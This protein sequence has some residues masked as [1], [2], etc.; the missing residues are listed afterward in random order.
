MRHH[1]TRSRA[2]AIA[3]GVTAGVLALGTAAAGTAA[4]STAPSAAGS[5]SAAARAAART[6]AQHQQHAPEDAVGAVD[7]FYSDYGAAQAAHDRAKAEKLRRRHL[8]PGGL[9]AVVGWERRHPGYDGVT[10]LKKLPV[11]RHVTYDGSGMGHS[12]TVVKQ[13]RGG[14]GSHSVHVQTDLST[15]RISGI[16]DMD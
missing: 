1:L 7:R 15:E 3:G 6:A 5:H 4:A 16:R 11:T 2:A 14:G 12:W 13:A 10:H 9:E 8:T